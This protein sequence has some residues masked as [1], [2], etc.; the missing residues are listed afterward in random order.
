MHFRKDRRSEYAAIF[1]PY[2]KASIPQANGISSNHYIEMRE[3]LCTR[4]NVRIGKNVNEV[5]CFE[6][7][8]NGANADGSE[9]G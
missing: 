8:P 3:H 6:L 2:E 1:E 9:A 5:H 7:P 4:S